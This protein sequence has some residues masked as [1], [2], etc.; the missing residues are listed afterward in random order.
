MDK[1]RIRKAKIEDAEALAS[2][3]VAAYAQYMPPGSRICRPCPT[4]AP[5]NL[6]K[7]GFGWQR[8]RARSLVVLFLFAK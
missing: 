3:I 5:M 4:D 1:T 6:Q 8:K 7:I 2:G